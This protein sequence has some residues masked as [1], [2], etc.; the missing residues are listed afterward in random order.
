[1]KRILTLLVTVLFCLSL[2][3]P[4]LAVVEKPADVYVGDYAVVLSAETKQYIIDA[5]KELNQKTG[6]Q[7]T[8]VTV[9]F[10]DGTEIEDYAYRIFNDWGIGD[11]KKNNGLLLLLS[12]GDDDYWVMQGK[13]LEGVLSSGTLGDMLYDELEPDFAKGN[14]DAGVR[15]VF[16]AFLNWFE[17]YYHVAINGSGQQSGGINREEES[18][19]EDSFDDTLFWVLLILI[20]ITIILFISFNKRNKDRHNKNNRNYPPGGGGSGY[21]RQPQP[22]RSVYIPP[23]TGRTHRSSGGFGSGTTNRRGG[24]FGGG[25][26]SGGGF[27]SS[28]GFGGG[29]SFGGGGSRGGGAGRR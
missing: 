24:S 22:R 4:A 28:G 8:I 15:K 2:T 9:D 12:I 19:D 10:L 27:G 5:N 6:A 11:A 16:D 3:Q 26:S 7:I 18:Y 29:S 23:S 17:D 21:N 1:M 13:G 14:Y 25:F 20:I